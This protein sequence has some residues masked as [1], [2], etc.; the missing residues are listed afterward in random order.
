MINIKEKSYILSGNKFF[1]VSFFKEPNSNVTYEEIPKIIH[2]E[3]AHFVL[4]QKIS[5]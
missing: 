4:M 2:T 3:C 5:H 1:Y